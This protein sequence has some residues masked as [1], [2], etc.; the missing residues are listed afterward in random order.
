MSLGKVSV[1]RLGSDKDRFGSFW[2]RAAKPAAPRPAPTTTPSAILIMECMFF[3]P[4]NY[5]QDDRRKCVTPA[6][7]G[8]GPGLPPRLRNCSEERLGAALA[9]EDQAKPG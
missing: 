9:R 4:W 1:V 2:A 7:H 8:F 5:G 6:T 3:S